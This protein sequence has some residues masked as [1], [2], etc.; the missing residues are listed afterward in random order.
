ME[1]LAIFPRATLGNGPNAFDW[2][3][4]AAA[5]H[6]I[7]L[8]VA[9]IEDIAT[10][11]SG[12]NM[13]LY[14]A[15]EQTPTPDITI[16]RGYDMALS[17]Q[18]E[19]MGSRVVNS[20]D[21]ML[22][23]HD[24]MLTHLRL[25]Q[26]GISTPATF[27]VDRSCTYDTA[28]ALVGDSRFVVK[29]TDGSRGINVSLVSDH[30]EFVSAAES[31]GR[32]M[33]VQRYVESSHGRDMRVWVIGGSV[34]CAVIRNSIDNRFVSN[35]SQGGNATL[36]TPPPEA[37][38]LAIAATEAIGLFFAGVD[39]LFDGDG[40]TVCEVNGNAG[41]HSAVAC[42][43]PDIIDFFFTKLCHIPN[44]VTSVLSK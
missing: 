32:N 31:C 6:G 4:C 19:L 5:A 39:L 18:L 43:A 36:C 1:G 24:K 29:Q 12:R 8:R 26:S 37:A 42:G 15:G 17:R 28:K 14:I 38:A 16:M 9:F 20:T 25:T 11:V 23:S 40:Y 33:L 44:N 3:R 34:V 13:S 10:G 22:T 7:N 27:L 2:W 30:S 41:F 21:S 35:Y